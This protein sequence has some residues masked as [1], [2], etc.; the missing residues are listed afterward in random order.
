LDKSGDAV[1]FTESNLGWNGSCG[2][3]DKVK[4][5][6]YKSTELY[7]TIDKEIEN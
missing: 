7:I 1:Q 3:S 4:D 6:R 2:D 5:S